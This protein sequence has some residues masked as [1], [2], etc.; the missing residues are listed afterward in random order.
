V[1]ELDQTAR[2]LAGS[3][4]SEL[5]G[6]LPG[7]A[8]ERTRDQA[9]QGLANA[10]GEAGVDA[11]GNAIVGALGEALGSLAEGGLE[12]AAQAAGAV[13]HG[14]GPLIDGAGEALGD[15]I[16]GILDGLGS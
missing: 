13:L 5:E 15:M 12:A 16:G 6:V 2:P 1:E 10:L 11:T 7:S 3:P 14:A 9:Q 4:A 8:G